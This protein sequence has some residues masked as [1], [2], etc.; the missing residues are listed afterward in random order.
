MGKMYIYLVETS[1]RSANI[2]IT[3]P[4]QKTVRRNFQ[5]KIGHKILLN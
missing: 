5:V 3:S 1:M 2:V 4:E